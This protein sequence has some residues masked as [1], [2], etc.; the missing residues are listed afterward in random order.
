[1]THLHIE[2]KVC[3]Y[4]GRASCASVRASLATRAQNMKKRKTR[5]EKKKGTVS[6][7]QKNTWS[8]DAPVS[9]TISFNILVRTW[10]C[11]SQCLRGMTP[12]T[13]INC[14]NAQLLKS[15]GIKCNLFTA[16]LVKQNTVVLILLNT[17]WF[18]WIECFEVSALRNTNYSRLQQ[19][20]KCS[21]K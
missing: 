17:C 18:L 14:S 3:T 21:W 20:N 11:I 8:N 19:Q 13:A 16:A 6:L 9:T 4:C 12:A 15:S 10:H 5:R 2:H 1:M 7:G